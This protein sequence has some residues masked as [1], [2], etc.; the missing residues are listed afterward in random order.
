MTP[1][2]GTLHVYN[3]LPALAYAAADWIVQRAK[4]KTGRFVLALSGGGTPKPIYE[5]LARPPLLDEFPWTRSV[6]IIGDERFVPQ[7]DPASNWGMIRQA[8]LDHVPVPVENL[9]PVT[10]VGLTLEEAAVE[11]ER[12]LKTLHG[13][14]TL[15]RLRPLFDVVLLGLGDDGHTASLLPNEP[16]L[17][18]T[19]RWV[20]PVPHGRDEGRI[21]LT[22]PA[23]NSTAAIAFLVAGAGKRQILDHVLSGATDV[24]AARL[25][26]VGEVHW[27]LDRAAA[28]DHAP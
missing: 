5:A 7:D 26:P 1:S 25:H 2:E 22:Y 10:T 28:G 14:D 9:V 16:V 12:R 13:A 21:T 18:I 8:M 27:F 3:D 4:A 24:P 11:Y 15:D 20:A 23:L 19:D 17:D 6:F